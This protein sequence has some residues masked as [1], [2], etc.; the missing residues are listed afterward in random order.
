MSLLPGQI[1]PQSTPLGRLNKDGTITI[2][3]NWWLLLYNLS[4][5]VLGTGPTPPVDDQTLTTEIDDATDDGNDVRPALADLERL[6]TNEEPQTT[7]AAA[8]IDE[9]QALNASFAEDPIIARFTA[10]WDGLVPASGGGTSKF[11]SASGAWAIPAYPAVPASANPSASVGLTPVD[12]TAT[13]Y[14]TSDSAS[15]LS[16]AI[17]P[18]WTG[19]HTWT[20]TLYCG[21]SGIVAYAL[22]SAGSNFA[23]IQNDGPNTWS[24]ATGSAAFNTLGTPIL[25]W[26]PTGIKLH[27]AQTSGWGTPTGASVVTNFP[28]AGPATLAQ[29]SETLAQI[30]QDLK[31][32]GLYGA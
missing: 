24:L 27:I 15:A 31:T 4:L 28:G 29:C 20:K 3:Q 21:I 2:D 14:M 5:Q 30:I 32:L 1:L 16:Q 11:L 26:A 6:A 25:S 23:Q 9:L 17:A 18:N 10:Q 12:G 7:T 19:Q 13:T 8:D 22:N